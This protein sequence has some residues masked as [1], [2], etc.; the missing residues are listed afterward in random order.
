MGKYLTPENTIADM[1]AHPALANFA[2]HILPRP[3]DSGVRLKFTEIGHLMPWHNHIEPQVVVTGVNRLIADSELGKQVFYSFYPNKYR[4]ETGLFFFRG[5][6]GQPFAIICP[7]GGFRYVGSLHEGFPVAEAINQAGFNAFVLQ[8]RIGVQQ[9]A[10]EDLARAIIW[11]LQNA[12][13]LQVSTQGYSLWGGSAGGR[14][15]AILGATRLAD[16]DGRE[17]PKPACVIVAY[18]GHAWIGPTDAPTFSV[19]GRDDPI[20]DAALMQKRINA[21]SKLGI[22]SEILVFD[23]VGHGFGAGHETAAAG[24]VSKAI[25]FWKRRLQTE[26]ME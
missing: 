8:Y 25:A 5:K 16:H 22:P 9:I 15:A 2:H 24:W 12:T 4:D 6:P 21:L 14:M 19:V 10:C 26:N 23:H 7:G 18:T 3:E 20:A 13:K 1:L 11:I 17:L